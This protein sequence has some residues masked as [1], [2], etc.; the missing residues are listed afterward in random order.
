MAVCGHLQLTT[1]RRAV[2]FIELPE[3]T[4]YCTTGR[5]DDF[6]C[7]RFPVFLT[8]VPRNLYDLK[9]CHSGT[10]QALAW[11]PHSWST[12]AQKWCRLSLS[13]THQFITN[14]RINTTMNK[15]RGS[16][17]SGYTAGRPKDGFTQPVLQNF[18]IESCRN[19]ETTASSLLLPGHNCT[20]HTVNGRYSKLKTSL[21][22]QLSPDMAGPFENYNLD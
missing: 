6:L 19:D 15:S 1:E 13:H 11:R 21:N 5:A 9:H 10:G 16:M 22:K 18:G 17:V 7:Y 8:A 12:D 4:S 3:Q 20:N 2:R 14:M